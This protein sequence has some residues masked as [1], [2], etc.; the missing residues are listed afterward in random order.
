MGLVRL[1]TLRFGLFLV[2]FENPTLFFGGFNQNSLIAYK[3][4]QNKP[5]YS[6][7]F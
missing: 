1:T 5:D 6:K 2:L 3:L 7:C 4:L